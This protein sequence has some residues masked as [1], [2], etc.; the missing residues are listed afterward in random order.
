MTEHKTIK[1][2]NYDAYY[3]FQDTNKPKVLFIHGFG[4]D[5]T[6]FIEL[7]EINKEY[8][9]IAVDLP[10]RG[11]TQST[12]KNKQEFLPA[13]YQEFIIDFIQTLNIKIDLVTS[14]SLGALTALYALD[15]NLIAKGLL[16]SPYNYVPNPKERNEILQNYLIPE[17]ELIAKLSI[18]DLTINRKKDFLEKLDAITIGIMNNKTFNETTFKKFV[19]MLVDEKFV[20]ETVKPLYIRNAKKIVIANADH[21]FYIPLTNVKILCQELK[22]KLHEVPFAGHLIFA[23]NPI[24]CNRLINL[25]IKK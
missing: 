1:L 16:F 8:D 23:D 24:E 15:A 14:T 22:I 7:K 20:N 9:L 4:G 5:H 25:Y 12:N 18:L 3:S 6:R 19:R 21:D 10:G 11:K 13:D 2:K 17:N